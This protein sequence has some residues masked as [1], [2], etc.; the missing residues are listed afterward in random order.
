MHRASA[1][2]RRRRTSRPIH[3]H[4]VSLHSSTQPVA[5]ANYRRISRLSDAI[6]LCCLNPIRSWP[7][8]HNRRGL[9]AL[10]QAVLCI[11]V[12]YRCAFV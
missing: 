4:L 7:N 3:R 6:P 10:V 11:C 12:F 8:F 5:R 1:R 2:Q 9:F